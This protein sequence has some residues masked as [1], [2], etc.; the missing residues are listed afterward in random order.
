MTTQSRPGAV[1]SLPACIP[2]RGNRLTRCLG[3]CLLRLFG[4]RVEGA[5]PEQTKM[6]LIG[7]PHSSNWDFILGM[8]AMFAIGIRISFFIKH[9]AFKPGLRHFLRWLGGVPV[10]RRAPGGIIEQTAEAMANTQR[11][12]VLAVTPEG[13]RR[14]VKHWKT[15][16][17]RIA[18]ANH[19]PVVPVGIDNQRRVFEIGP[20]FE[21]SGEQSSDFATMQAWFQRFP[22][23]E[24]VSTV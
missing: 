11:M 24:Q 10:N 2:S 23:R 4:W 9:T 5:F 7:A 6:V 20:A 12:M 22:R 21:L 19:L 1:P 18:M 16:F 17:Y 15:G 8:A 14:A 3:R 13:T